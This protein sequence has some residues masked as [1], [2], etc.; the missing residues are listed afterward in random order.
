MNKMLLTKLLKKIGL[1]KFIRSIYNLIGRYNKQTEILVDN[2]RIKFWTPTFYL[3]DYI[4][5]FAGEE[6][7]LNEL[8][9]RLNNKNTF[10]DIGANIRFYSI[11][12]AKEM[13][14]G[15][16][17]FAF[18]PEQKTFK[19]LKNNIELNE[20]KN[21]V[22][23]PYA[24]GDK[25]GEKV[26]YSSDTPNFGAHS[27]VQRT[28]YKV[29]KKGSY[30]KVITG[31]ELIKNMNIEIPDMMKIDVEGAEILVLKGMENL[32]RNSKLKMILCEVHINLLPLFN[33]SEHEV[34]KIIKKESFNLDFCLNR[35]NQNQYLFVR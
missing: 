2:N 28:D 30:I 25:N 17:I 19:L 6:A 20:S 12:I 22:A 32:L 11:I 23:L 3:N 26:L 9:L 35:K 29:K 13:K 16:K 14:I 15:S 27:F 10:W 31:D 34:V 21:I 8:I 18:E 5:N 4:K 7:L 24:L 33:S 1:Y